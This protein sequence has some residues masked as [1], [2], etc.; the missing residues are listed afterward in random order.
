MKNILVTGGAGVIGTH[1]CL[2]LLEKGYN[3]F[4]TDSYINSSENSL[5]KVLE[6][7]EKQ[8]Q[9]LK[10]KLYII[11]AD[12]K[13]K[14]DIDKA[15]QSS[16]KVNKSIDAVIH[17]AGLKSVSESINEPLKYWENN[18]IGTIN[19]LKIMEKY[20]CKTIIFSSSAT[21]YKAKSDELLKENDICEPVNPY[22]YTKLTIERI[23]CDLY[24]SYPSHWRIASLRYFNPV[25]AHYS[26]LIGEDPLGKP[27]NIY[28]QITRVG[29]GKLDEIKIFGSDWPTKDGTGVR[30]YIHVMDLA[31]GHLSA[32]NYL[33]NEKPQNLTINLGTGKG[34]SVLE[35]IKIFQKVNDVN[36]PYRFVSRR[37]GDNPYVVADNSLAKLILNWEPKFSID[38]I[39]RSGWNW[40]LKNP[41]GYEK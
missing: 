24:E 25:G 22:G 41:N 9:S 17:F 1:T 13:I 36:I 18:V 39:C 5:K 21:V 23:L 35:L 19:L 26:G 33:I 10:K 8:K 20:H 30:D 34:I 7:L 29:V 27:N 2:L 16:I 3:V 32:L 37:L 15:F 31:E 40:Q 14:S 4:T 6:I 28:P 12:L 38:D 11:E